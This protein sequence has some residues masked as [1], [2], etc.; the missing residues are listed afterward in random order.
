LLWWWCLVSL[1]V[2]NSLFS[3][4]DGE[5]L[6]I[7]NRNKD[8]GVLIYNCVVIFFNDVVWMLTTQYFDPSRLRGNHCC[9]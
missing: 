6:I 3:L 9:I 8:Y 2:S 4:G 5:T 7:M 1:C